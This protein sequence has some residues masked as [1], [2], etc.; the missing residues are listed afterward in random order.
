VQGACKYNFQ[1]TNIND[2]IQITLDLMLLEIGLII[3]V[4]A[5]VAVS[6]TWLVGPLASTLGSK[7]RMAGLVNMI[8]NHIPAATPR[9]VA[10]PASLVY[11]YV[12]QHFVVNGSC[13]DA[14]DNAPTILPTLTMAPGPVTNGRLV[15]VTITFDSSIKGSLNMAWLGPWG[16]IESTNVTM[17]ASTP[18]K[19]T[20]NVPGDLSGHV[21]GVLTG[22]VAGSEQDLAKMAVAGPEV[23]WVTQP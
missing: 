22:G 1:L 20:A 18:G 6:D 14:V 13:P 19:G 16:G 8:Q 11:S 2:F 15:S 12:S 5:Q 21:W 23:V 7:A 10:I 3:D 9:E 17:D 4:I